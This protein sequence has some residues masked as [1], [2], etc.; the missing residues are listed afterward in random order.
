MHHLLLNEASLRLAAV[1]TKCW[2]FDGHF[3]HGCY[4]TPALPYVIVTAMDLQRG[5]VA[6][7]EHLLSKCIQHCTKVK[8]W[9]SRL[10][11]KIYAG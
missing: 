9:E 2:H 6:L 8:Q 5:G 7:T 3:F 11:A 10:N 4:N 1:E